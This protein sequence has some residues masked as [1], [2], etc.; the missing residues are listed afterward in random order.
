MKKA[1]NS[2]NLFVFSLILVFFIMCGCAGNGNNTLP[3]DN[4]SETQQNTNS[5]ADTPTDTS[6]TVVDGYLD[7][8]TAYSEVRAMVGSGATFISH[9]QGFTKDGKKAWV[10]VVEPITSSP[11]ETTVTYYVGLDFCY[12]E[13]S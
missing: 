1:F 12:A 4:Q 5:E 11:E 9:E 3:T 10:V 2:R 6:N 13:D 8:P 7:W